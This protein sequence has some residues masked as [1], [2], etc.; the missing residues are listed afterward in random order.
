[1]ML[2]QERAMPAVRV[3]GTGSMYRY[4]WGFY[5]R[6]TL[7][8]IPFL[9]YFMG[10]SVATLNMC[11]KCYRTACPGS[12]L[13]K[14][15]RLGLI[16]ALVLSCCLIDFLPSFGIAVYP[17][18]FVAIIIYTLI[19]FYILGRHGLITITPSFAADRIIRIMGDCLMVLENEGHICVANSS[20]TGFSRRRPVDYRDAPLGVIGRGRRVAS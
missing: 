3:P 17:L 15:W 4:D 1:M 20:M 19:D 2:M 12:M 9:L 11:V 5:P 7:H 6:N 16:A 13:H 10:G 14:R 8:S 18:G